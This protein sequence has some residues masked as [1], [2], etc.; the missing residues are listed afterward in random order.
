MIPQNE[1]NTSL[2][3]HLSAFLSFVFPF[4]SV[5]GPLVLWIVSKDKSLNIDETGKEAVNFNLT[6]T[7]YIF[8][9]SSISIPFA[10]GSL[11]NNMRYID[12]FDG[13]NMHLNFDHLFG[14]ISIASLISILGITRFVLVIIAAIKASRGEAYKYPLTINFIK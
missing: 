14:L 4:G 1:R 10:F 11:F 2:L 5:V 6:Y 3:I 7:L 13:F 8:V 9:L 12:D